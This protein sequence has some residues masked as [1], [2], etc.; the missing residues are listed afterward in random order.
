MT[1]SLWADATVLILAPTGKDAA[2][3]AAT[4]G[5]AAI[6]TQICHDFEGI[7]RA[8]AQ[9]ADVLLIA[10]EALDHRRLQILADAL[11]RQPPWSDLPILLVARPGADSPLIAAALNCLGNVTL[12]ERP[13]RPATLVSAAQ[14]ALKSR[15]RQYEVRLHLLERQRTEEALREADRRKDEFIA[16]LAHELRNP[17]APIQNSLHIL[18]LAAPADLALKQIQE[19]LERQTDLLVRLVDDLLEVSRI[20]QGKIELRLAV[21]DLA[22]VIR[23]AIEISCPAIQHYEHRLEVALPSEPLLVYGDAARLSQVFCNLLNNAAKYTHAGG[24]IS[25]AARREDGSALVSVTDNG[26]GIAADKLPCIFDMFTQIDRTSRQAQGGLGIGLSLVRALIEMHGGRIEAYSAG[27]GQG[28]EFRVT[29]PLSRELVRESSPPAPAATSALPRHR[30]L[31]VDDNR[32]ASRS[33]CRLL[34]LLGAEV[35]VAHDGPQALDMLKSYRPSVVLLDIGMPNMDGYEVARRIR[36]H[37]EW[38]DV[39][40]I[41]VTGW[42]Q[43]Q[44]RRRTAEAGFNHHLV[45]PAKISDIE[46]LLALNEV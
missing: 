40:L 27:L 33:L 32:D 25:I 30:V 22:A 45:K 14:A 10:E 3:T 8:I 26:V 16:T 18:R 24:R 4:L 36:S 38:D 2:L 13:L 1:D 41:A 7:H 21:V 44:D 20:T 29:L 19:T 35:E 17:L 5:K 34:R 12:L 6:K 31:V 43:D 28:S 39:V 11:A 9:P 42:G 15:A 23:Q 46:S 37:S